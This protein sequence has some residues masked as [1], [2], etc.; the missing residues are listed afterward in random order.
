MSVTIINTWFL[1]LVINYFRLLQNIKK[2]S[3]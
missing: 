1:V 2:C 3:N